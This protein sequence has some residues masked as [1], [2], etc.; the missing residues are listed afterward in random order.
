MPHPRCKALLAAAALLAVACESSGPGGPTAL[1]LTIQSPHGAEGAALISLVGP[2][3]SVTR[4]AP[5]W[6]LAH[7]VADTTWVFAGLETAGIL[8]FTVH[9]GGDGRL[10]GASLVEVSGPDDAPRADPDR[11]RLDIR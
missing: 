8:R 4:T 2:V 7:R 5:G 1:G 9:V 11:Y 3:D 10:D 6:L